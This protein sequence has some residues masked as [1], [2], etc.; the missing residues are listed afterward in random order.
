M[1]L[2]F[3]HF[4]SN[5]RMNHTNLG[6]I[7]SELKTLSK[8]Q[9]G[10]FNVGSLQRPLDFTRLLLERD[11]NPQKH[12]ENFREA[13]SVFET[14][15]SQ[16]EYQNPPEYLSEGIRKISNQY[17]QFSDKIKVYIRSPATARRHLDYLEGIQLTIQTL[18]NRVTNEYIAKF[19]TVVNDIT[20]IYEEKGG[21]AEELITRVAEVARE[22]SREL[23]DPYHKMILFAKSVPD[24]SPTIL[25]RD[26]MQE[27]LDRVREKYPEF[28]KS[29]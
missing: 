10:R 7:E 18:A 28:L 24:M 11:E 25:D 17:S 16:P 15:F 26:E 23:A 6:L 12:L 14:H 2:G 21:S 5:Y 27:Y 20:N 19:L 22:K 1:I 3:K 29:D 4:P 13:F 9:M 8:Y